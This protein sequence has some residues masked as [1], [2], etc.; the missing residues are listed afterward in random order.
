M[1]DSAPRPALDG[2]ILALLACMV[3]TQVLGDIWLS[4]GMK[5]F[6]E[7]NRYDLAALGQLFSYLLTSPWILFG[8][9]TLACSLF[10]YLTAVSRLDLSLVLPIGS[11][12]YILNAVMAQWILGEAVSGLRWLATVIIALGVFMVYHGEHQHRQISDPPRANKSKIYRPKSFW[13]AFP[14]GL[15]FS[16][17]WAGI[18]LWVLADSAGDLLLT[19]GMKQ[20]GPVSVGSP[21]ALVRVLGEILFH[22]LILLGIACQAIAFA[23]FISLLSWADISLIRPATSLGYGVSLL[24]ARFILKEQIPSERWLGIVII[25]LGVFTISLDIPK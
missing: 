22:P 25:G 3:M 15:Y 14:L 8:V 10:L 20:M 19:Q 13:L 17:V 2:K 7:V 4:R 11:S 6:G 12:S 16:R 18:L 9:A 23:C 5:L 21:R 1:T 24:G